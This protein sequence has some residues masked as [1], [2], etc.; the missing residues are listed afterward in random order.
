MTL[1]RFSGREIGI[2][3]GFFYGTP[4]SDH[5]LPQKIGVIDQPFP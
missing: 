3:I 5:F 4:M 1:E 2:L